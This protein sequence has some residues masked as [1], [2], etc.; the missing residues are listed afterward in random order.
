MRTT[1]VITRSEALAPHDHV[2]WVYVRPDAFVAAARAFLREGVRRGERIG[3]VGGVGTDAMEA[4]LRRLAEEERASAFVEDLGAMYQGGT[5]NAERQVAFYGE[6]TRDALRD[7]HTGLRVAADCT[8][9]VSDEVGAQ[10]FARY[11]HLIDREMV[12][13]PFTATC[14]FDRS[15]LGERV[16]R[17]ACLHPATNLEGSSFGVY[18]CGRHRLGLW[19][20]IDA[21]NEVELDLALERAGW[22]ALLPADIDATGTGYLDHHAL[23][24]LQRRLV[25]ADATTR[26]RTRQEIVRRLVR[27]LGHDRIEVEVVR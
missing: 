15:V 25:D 17:L 23:S 1:G 22:P 9:L 11:E 19:G 16:A 6:A 27:L 7:G 20:D 21:G 13:L 18:A 4:E 14:G 8:L 12:T 26:L 24:V 10:A 3:Y 2:A 5:P